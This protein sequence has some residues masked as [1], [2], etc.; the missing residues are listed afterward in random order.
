MWC[1]R[2]E[3]YLGKGAT[4]VILNGYDYPYTIMTRILKLPTKQL[5]CV[6]IFPPFITMKSKNNALKS[7]KCGTNRDFHR[8]P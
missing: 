4:W 1:C 7:Q 3:R 5:N 2:V 6:F 8:P